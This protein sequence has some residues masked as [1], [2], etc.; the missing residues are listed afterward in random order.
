MYKGYGLP[1]EAE[2][3]IASHGLKNAIYSISAADLKEDMFGKLV[4]CP[5]QV[6]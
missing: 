5:F 6:C 2:E 4:A 3:K 1:Q